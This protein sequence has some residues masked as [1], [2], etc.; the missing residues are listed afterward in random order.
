MKFVDYYIDLMPDGSILIDEEL[1]ADCLNI[2]NG[3]LFK[4][5]VLENKLMFKKQPPKLIWEQN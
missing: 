4:A 2:S 5:E 1:K 3:D